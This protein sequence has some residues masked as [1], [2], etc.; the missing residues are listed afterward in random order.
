MT[1]TKLLEPTQ[2]GGMSLRNRLVFPATST[3]LSDRNGYLTDREKAFQIERARGGT[4][5]VIVPG[6]VDPGGRSFPNVAGIWEDGQIDGWRELA[7]GV[8]SYGSRACVQLM[9][10][11]RYVHHSVGIQPVAASAVPPR[12]PRY[13][14]CRELSIEEIHEMVQTFGSAARRTREAGFDAVE[15]LACTGYLVSTFISTWAN[16]RTDEY[17]GSVENRT[18]FLLEIIREVKKQAP[19]LPLL[20]RL[21]A[22][23]I[24]PGGTPREELRQT[25]VMAQEAGADAISLTVG[26]HESSEPAITSE[27]PAGAWLPLAAQW[28][29]VLRVP[30]IMAYRLRTPEVAERALQQGQVDLVAMCRPLICEPAMANKLAE[31]RPED[32]IPCIT[33]NQGCFQRLFNAAWVQ[34]LMNPLT[35]RE[36]LPEYRLSPASRSKRVLV[37]GGGPAGLEA[38]RV[39]ATRGHHVV[40]CEKAGRLGGLSNLAAVPPHRQEMA[41]IAGY[42]VRQV[43]K[44]GVEIRLNTTVTPN[45]AR[46]IAPDAIIVATGAVLRLPGLE[47]RGIPTLT[48]HQV[49]AGEATAGQRVVVWGG[50]EAGAQTAELLAVRGHGVTIVEGSSRLAKDMTAFDRVG[51]KTRLRNLGVRAI[52]GATL[53]AAGGEIFAITPQGRESLQADSVVLSLGLTPNQDLYES[54]KAEFAEVNAVGDCVTPRKALH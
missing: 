3:N 52:T 12:I 24:L 49:L 33:C 16:R 26:W 23:E 27:I 10:A 38:A 34:C 1:F 4:G 48:A 44:L 40:L 22:D 25:A 51:L 21:N 8:K 46:Q 43:Q 17:G 14:P 42:L 5:L 50:D 19:G 20:V 47:L 31:G 7:S 13:V 45:L 6:Y 39:A 18:R 54:L 41:D 11:G 29:E 32:V 2:I 30:V 53:E 37:V 28:K 9:H 15:I 36:S 35:G